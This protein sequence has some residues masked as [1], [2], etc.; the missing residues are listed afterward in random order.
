MK[1]MYTEILRNLKST[2]VLFFK[3]IKLI[4]KSLMKRNR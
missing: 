3:E 1:E 2:I 4:I